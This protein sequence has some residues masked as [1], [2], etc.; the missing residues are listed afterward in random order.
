MDVG[1]TAGKIV[2][3]TS[4]GQYP[5]A[6]GFLITNLSSANMPGVGSVTSVSSGNGLLGGTFTTGGTLSVDTGST[7]NKIVQI[8]SGGQ[9]PQADGFLVTNVN[10]A[11]LQGRSVSASGPAGGQVL[12]WNGTTAVWEPVSAGGSGTVQNVVAGTGMQPNTITS[13]GTLSVDVGSTANKIVQMTVGG[14]DRK[15]VV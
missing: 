15:S 9:Y 10:A 8:T 12:G 11:K 6:D 14:Q 2:Q 1:S 5:K 7:A 3:I 13:S 4:G